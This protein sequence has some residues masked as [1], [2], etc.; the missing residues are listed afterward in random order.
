MTN[1]LTLT[2]IPLA[3]YWR[4]LD[5]YGQPRGATTDACRAALAS[6]E[7]RID[8]EPDF[9]GI[10]PLAQ[11]VAEYMSLAGPFAED[12]GEFSGAGGFE[13]RAAR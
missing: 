3:V 13:V 5:L 9:P 12:G 4:A 11:A 7:S 8:V 6:A 10:T 2:S 1:N